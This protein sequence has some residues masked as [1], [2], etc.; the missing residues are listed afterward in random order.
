MIPLNPHRGLS[1]SARTN[2]PQ[3]QSGVGGGGKGT[4]C[5]CCS[6]ACEPQQFVVGNTKNI[7]VCG[8]IAIPSS[9]SPHGS[10]NTPT[11]LKLATCM[12]RKS[13]LM[14]VCVCGGVCGRVFVC[15]LVHCTAIII[16]IIYENKILHSSICSALSH[17]ACTS[18]DY[19]L[20]WR[21]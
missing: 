18:C 11:E 7:N 10:R 15:G 8:L 3:P 17:A 9:S 14:H 19:L 20:T 21:T 13:P 4:Q 2:R 5:C 16:I 1:D 12:N 6:A